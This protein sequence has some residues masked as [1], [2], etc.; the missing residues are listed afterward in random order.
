VN[1]KILIVILV[2]IGGFMLGFIT[3][4][5]FQ[6]KNTTPNKETSTS[7]N[8]KGVN[9]VLSVSPQK[10]KSAEDEK[11][12]SKIDKTLIE[13]SYTAD[14][15]ILNDVKIHLYIEGGKKYELDPLPGTEIDAEETKSKGVTVLRGPSAKPGEKKKVALGIL[16]REKGKAKIFADV[17]SAKRIGRSNS[18]TLEIN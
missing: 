9:V 11:D 13:V 1:K 3:F 7:V 18:V 10:I 5:S 17:Y 15:V 8:K 16:S 2:I 12:Y 14:T 4:R 6:S